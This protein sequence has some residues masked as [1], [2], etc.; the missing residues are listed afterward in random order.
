[1]E[2][3]SELLIT[4][5]EGDAGNGFFMKKSKFSIRA[6]CAWC[7]ITVLW[8]EPRGILSLHPQTFR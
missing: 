8:L 1:M 6:A 3:R 7:V 5:S 4:H 2:N